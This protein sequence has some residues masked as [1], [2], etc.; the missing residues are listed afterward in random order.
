MQRALCDHLD[1]GWVGVLRSGHELCPSRRE[2]ALLRGLAVRV[3]SRA[4]P[5]RHAILLVLNPDNIVCL[6]PPADLPVAAV[7]CQ[8]TGLL[9]AQQPTDR[10]MLGAVQPAQLIHGLADQCRDHCQLARRRSWSDRVS[11]T[12]VTCAPVSLLGRRGDPACPSSATMPASVLDMAFVS[13]ELDT[14]RL[15][16]STAA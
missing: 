6:A 4:Q 11:F 3:S 1:C 13:I 14:R 5:P 9:V 8:V 2:R 15:I 7:G 10:A 12:P 16:F